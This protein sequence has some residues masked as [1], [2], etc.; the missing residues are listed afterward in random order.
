MGLHPIFTEL[1]HDHSGVIVGHC[2]EQKVTLLVQAYIM[3]WACLIIYFH[4]QYDTFMNY[5]VIWAVKKAA[6]LKQNNC[7]QQWHGICSGAEWTV[8]QRFQMETCI[9]RYPFVWL[10]SVSVHFMLLA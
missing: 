7:Q 4:F 8:F 9:I 5:F 2:W 3:C 10:I 6:L 1:L